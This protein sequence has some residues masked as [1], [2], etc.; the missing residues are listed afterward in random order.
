M[1]KPCVFYSDDFLK[2]NAV[3]HPECRGRLEWTM[4]RLRGGNL[5]DR[6]EFKEPRPASVIEVEGVHAPSYVEGILR[7]GECW[8]DPDTYMSRGS[9]D[10]ALKAAGAAVEGVDEALR[11][12]K[13]SVGMVR[14]PGHH[15]LPDHAMGF[16][17]FNNAAIGTMHALESLK[18]VIIVDW[19]VH[20]GNGTELVFYERPDVLYFST[21]EYPHYPGTGSASD[22]GRGEGEGFN[23]N[24]PLPAGSTDPD[25]IEA[26]EAILVPIMD[27]YRPGLVVI[28][29]GFDAHAADP[30]GDMKMTEAGFHQ[31]AS[32]VREGAKNAGIVVLLE[33]GYSPEHLP[34]S[35]EAALLGLM[36]EPYPLKIPGERTGAAAYYIEA[37]K[38]IQKKYWRL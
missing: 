24:V 17:I 34:A 27:S 20:H 19:D 36:G 35:V 30:L 5:R 21:H 6:L 23:V 1:E 14:P 16:C 9:A 15:A 28:S 3:G 22:T 32:I 18:K 10:V 12:R 2:H 4:A 7:S 37:A 11:G 26:F 13:L 8:L 31:L 33:G 38:K 25:L 29:A